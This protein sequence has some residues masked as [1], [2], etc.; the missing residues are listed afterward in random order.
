MN[1]D[2]ELRE[3]LRRQAAPPDFAAK[4]L[5]KANAPLPFPK[6]PVMS[7]PFTLAIAAGVMAVAIIPSV[8]FEYQRREEAK[9]IKA[10]QDLLIALAI[11][12]TQLRQAKEMIRHNTRSTQ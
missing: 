7:R 11:T 2:N 8:V 9:G 5:A 10:K 6:K 4:V 1:L 3:A 12:K